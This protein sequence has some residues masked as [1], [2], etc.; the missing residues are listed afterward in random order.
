MTVLRAVYVFLKLKNAW[1][2][3]QAFEFAAPTLA[4]HP[5]FWYGRLDEWWCWALRM[6]TLKKETGWG[7][8]MSAVLHTWNLSCRWHSQWR[9]SVGRG[10]WLWRTGAQENSGPEEGGVFSTELAASHGGDQGC[11]RSV[12]R[13]SKAEGQGQDHGV[14]PF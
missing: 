3:S 12:C 9:G 14:H 4:K 1:V 5:A 10:S 2:P 7:I 6:W 8:M 11:Q 13:G